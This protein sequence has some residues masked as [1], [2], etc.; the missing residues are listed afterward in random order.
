MKNITKRFLLSACGAVLLAGCAAQP[1]SWEYRTRTTD[2]P[3]GKSVLDEYGKSGWEL[4]G[5]T[6][7]AK[8]DTGTNF[9][10]QYTFKR[11]VFQNPKK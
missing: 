5:C 7:R 1:A 2:N 9:E 4:A 6:C 8:D 10:Y 11:P 3:K